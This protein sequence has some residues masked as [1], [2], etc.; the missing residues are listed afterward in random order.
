[1]N[2]FKGWKTMVVNGLTLVVAITAWP[3]VVALVDPQVLLFI[4][5][6]ANMVLRYFT[7]TSVGKSD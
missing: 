5:A 7:T 4:S 3:E 1:M 2:K 6:G